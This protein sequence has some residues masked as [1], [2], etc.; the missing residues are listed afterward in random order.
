ML[1]TEERKQTDMQ[2]SDSSIGQTFS[3]LIMYRLRGR[4]KFIFLGFY[5]FIN[6]IQ[7]IMIN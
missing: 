1:A 4:K 7:I 2:H 3:Y 6:P 5:V